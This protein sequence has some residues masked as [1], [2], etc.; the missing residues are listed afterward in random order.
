MAK[1]QEK[2][3][4]DLVTAMKAKEEDRVSVLRLLLADVN[5]VAKEKKDKLVDADIEKV[6]KQNVKRRKDAIASA[7]EAGRDDII[8]KEEAEIVTIESYLPAQMSEE[9]AVKAV[10]EVI[11]ETEAS[12]S[13]F[14]KVMGQVM[15][16]LKGQA[17]GN[18]VSKLVKEKLSKK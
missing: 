7:K 17:D 8:K 15:A 18:I 6:L 14:G 16:K 12:E 11:K 10:D 3:S 9:E 5:S 1:L 4:Q 2:I 13:D